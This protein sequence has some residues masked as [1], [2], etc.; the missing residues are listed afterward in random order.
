MHYSFMAVVNGL[1][2]QRY[3]FMVEGKN[4]YLG[5]CD[6]CLDKKVVTVGVIGEV[7]WRTFG[8]SH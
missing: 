7:F 2:I 6:L 1:G 8:K 4:V 5:L 3:C